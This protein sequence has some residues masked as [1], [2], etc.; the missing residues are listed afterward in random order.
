MG[1]S[2]WWDS[3]KDFVKDAIDSAIDAVVDIGRSIVDIV[4]S[5]FGANFDTP[6]V[7]ASVAQNNIVGPL[8]NKD[9]GVGPIPI[10]YG[11]RRVGGYRVFV[12]T[13]GTDNQ[14]LYVA[15]VMSEGQING[16]SQLLVDDT[17]VPLSSY[18]HGVQATPT[19][20]AYSGRLVCQFFDGRDDQTVSSLLD[21]A[22]GWGSNH[23]LRGLAYLA[24]RF[25]W[26]KITS[27]ADADNNPYRGG[28]PEINAVITGRKIYDI[29]DGFA[30]TD[31]AELDNIT[32]GNGSVPGNNPIFKIGD[33]GIFVSESDTGL[34]TFTSLSEEAVK[35]T[36]SQA[37]N[38]YVN[39]SMRIT[40]SGDPFIPRSSTN[41]N[42]LNYMHPS[43]TSRIYTGTPG[44]TGMENITVL[45]RGY[46][47][48][49]IKSGEDPQTISVSY[50]YYL[51]PGVYYIDH[52]YTG[53]PTGN[54]SYARDL[55]L[56]VTW[57]PPASV[58]NSTDYENETIAYNNNPVNV[59]LDYLRNPRY[60]KGLDNDYFDWTSW[61]NAARQC[62]QIVPY[63][64]DTPT[65][66]KYFTCNAVVET[67]NTLMSNI[68]TFLQ[69]FR[70][71]MPYQ[72]GKYHLKVDHSGDDNN[73]DNALANPPVVLTI[74][75]DDII[76]GIQISGED[77]ES[78]INQARITYTDPDADY[79][80]NDVIWPP[81]D[82]AIYAT[83]KSQDG[84]LELHKA[85][86]LPY[87]TSREQALNYAETMV[88]KSRN[89]KTI[90]FGC[91]LVAAN[92]SVGDIIRVINESLNFD[93]FF[94]VM[95][96]QL[97]L[98]ASIQIGAAQH[99]PGDYVLD[100]HAAAPARPV[101][102]LPDP[103]VVTAPSAVTVQSGAAFNLITNTDSY[104][105][106]DATVVR[107]FVSWVASSDPYVN[108]YVIRFKLDSDSEYQEAGIT[109]NTSFFIPGVEVG[110]SYDV[111]V[112]ARNQLDRQSNYAS[113]STHTVV[114]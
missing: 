98:D 54:I 48:R 97:G 65:T 81:E 43:I 102:N 57:D 29:L 114:S 12:S 34:T 60:G 61:R 70:G 46:D 59:L 22:P 101:L 104:V 9:S 51:E 83:Y 73:V 18:A 100:G 31:V 53:F 86:T 55:N 71:I 36:V 26:K 2:D 42:A 56:S 82:S 80:P 88:K 39:Q 95:Q 108:D 99:N 112:A 41:P 89:K 13:N 50:T 94:R 90:S 21:A 40:I 64:N 79:Q 35:I 20:G 17:V 91:T 37:T 107:L 38:L 32:Y 30:F 23:R 14:Y 105:E 49:M 44:Q 6:D 78:K 67:G 52:F 87:C 5:P 103:L 85:I 8:V 45:K 74:T 7:N 72:Q 75:K 25:Q 111:Q 77:K 1:I 4:M 84:D 96:V 69:Q 110:S 33:T 11:T 93:G 92:V 106:E 27:Q 28:I 10:V 47:S 3:A 63:D 19:S 66:G 24:L 113:A 15:I 16:F 68:K 109:T 58:A 62:D 76:G